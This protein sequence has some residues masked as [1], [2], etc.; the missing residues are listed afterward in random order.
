LRA[1]VLIDEAVAENGEKE[2]RK[3]RFQAANVRQMRDWMDAI[4]QTKANFQPRIETAFEKS[5]IAVR[6]VYESTQFQVCVAI[7]ILINFLCNAV[8][9]ELLP[10][11]G[12]EA[13][14]VLQTF[15]LVFVALFTIELAINMFANLVTRFIADG[16]NY[17]DTFVVI[18]SLVATFADENPGLNVLRM[19]RAFRV[20]RL[21]R[22]LRS[23]GKII[24]AIN[25]SLPAVG[26]AFF[27]VLL[28]TS[29]YAIM[30]TSFFRLQ[31]PAS[32][33]SFSISM[34]TMF[35]IMTFDD[36]AEVTLDIMALQSSGSDQFLVVL[37]TISFQLFVGFIL[38]NIVMYETPSQLFCMCFQLC[39]HV[40]HR[41]VATN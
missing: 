29:I 14:K 27:L 13:D 20:F 16:W 11:K 38:C 35:Q 7:A 30:G 32:F 34:Y 10:E 4:K 37:F 36:S 5:R 9:A 24:R 25:Q 12:S 28:M 17:F 1:R 41:R 3:Y 6:V 8:E 19:V 23:L 33:N 31:Y 18:I 40:E 22:R 2:G 21:F 39:S 26:N 15:D